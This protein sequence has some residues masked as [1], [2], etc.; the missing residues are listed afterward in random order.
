MLFIKSKKSGYRIRFFVLLLFLSIGHSVCNAHHNFGLYYDSSKIVTITGIVK[1]YAFINPH[2]EIELEVKQGA[3]ITQ[4]KVKTINARLAATYDLQKDSFKVGDP[5]EIKG[6]PAKDGSNTLGGHQLAL[7]DGQV[8]V[9]RRSPNESPVKFRSIHGFL[10]E[11]RQPTPRE[12]ITNRTDSQNDF[13]IREADPLTPAHR[14]RSGTGGRGLGR[15]RGEGFIQSFPLTA[16][17]DRDG[18]GLISESEIEGAV[19]ALE[20]L[21]QNQ[22]GKLTRDEL[23]PTSD[24]A[25][26]REGRRRNVPE[27]ALQQ[28][29]DSESEDPQIEFIEQMEEAGFAISALKELLE[30]ERSTTELQ[31]TEIENLQAALFNSKVLVQLIKISEDALGYHKGDEL[32]ARQGMKQSLLKAIDITLKIEANIING[33]QEAALQDLKELLKFQRQSH[34]IYQ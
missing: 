7:P 4:W 33:K 20:G 31:L 17:L 19:A 13:S 34:K 29:D 3:N 27:Q 28:L 23:R 26:G 2:I 18:D 9:L 16:S 12:T 14:N 1:R 5:V 6:W 10:G 22:D 30:D 11:K 25:R 8:F 21:D 24:T 15:Q 32:K